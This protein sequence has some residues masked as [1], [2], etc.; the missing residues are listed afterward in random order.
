MLLSL[1]LSL[2]EYDNQTNRQFD[3]ALNDHLNAEFCKG[4]KFRSVV[5]SYMTPERK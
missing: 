1:P 3:E 2:N 5:H 4:Y